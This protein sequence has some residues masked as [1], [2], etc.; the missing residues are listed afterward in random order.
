MA[1]WAFW[2]FRWYENV[3]HSIHCALLCFRQKCR[4]SWRELHTMCS[5]FVC[6]GS[7][8]ICC[9]KSSRINSREEGYR[10][11]LFQWSS[12]VVVLWDMCLGT[13]GPRD[14]MGHG[15]TTHGKR[16]KKH[17]NPKERSS[18]HLW[19]REDMNILKTV[20]YTFFC[21]LRSLGLLCLLWIYSCDYL[22]PDHELSLIAQC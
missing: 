17:N 20:I 22:F 3:H 18:K 8:Y 15:R 6:P 10:R 4:K 2:M 1:T 21:V 5:S 12:N 7:E 9:N 14:W 11:E 19:Y 13:R 16:I